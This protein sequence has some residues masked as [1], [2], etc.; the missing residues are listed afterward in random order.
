MWKMSIGRAWNVKI[1]STNFDS[2]VKKVISTL[3]LASYWAPLQNYCVKQKLVNF[4]TLKF[5]CLLWIFYKRGLF[6]L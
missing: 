3:V 1:F 2:H 6:D 5:G 4:F